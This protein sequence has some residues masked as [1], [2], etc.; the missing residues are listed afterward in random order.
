M[1][2]SLV[3]VAVA[4]AALQSCV[5]AVPSPLV[6]TSPLLNLLDPYP[7]LPLLHFNKGRFKLGTPWL[8]YWRA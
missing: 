8:Q 2:S 7:K 3:L 6:F 4:L 5:E 1:R